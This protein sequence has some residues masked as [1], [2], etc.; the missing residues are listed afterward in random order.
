MALP[1]AVCRDLGQASYPV[2][3][4]LVKGGSRAHSIPHTV[5]A[6]VTTASLSLLVRVARGM[7]VAVCS[8]RQSRA[9]SSSLK[10]IDPDVQ[11]LAMDPGGGVG[12]HSSFLT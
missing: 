5:P 7:K 11:A 10:C 4:S 9:V 12:A 6:A 1:D 3:S 2:V 8:R